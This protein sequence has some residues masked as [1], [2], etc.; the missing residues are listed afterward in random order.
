M[1]IAIKD[2]NK[3]RVI[4]TA[5]LTIAPNNITSI[6]GNTWAEKRVHPGD[7]LLISSTGELS[8]SHAKDGQVFLVIDICDE[9]ILE[10]SG[11]SNTLISLKALTEPIYLYA[12]AIAELGYLSDISNAELE[13]LLRGKWATIASLSDPL[14]SFSD[15]KPC[16]WIH[17]E[18][19]KIDLFPDIQFGI[20]PDG[21]VLD[22]LGWDGFNFARRFGVEPFI[23]L[24]GFDSETHFMGRMKG[25]S[26][27]PLTDWMPIRMRLYLCWFK[28]LSEK[29]PKSI[30]SPDETYFC[31]AMWRAEP[32]AEAIKVMQFDVFVL[33]H[34][35]WRLATDGRD[36]AFQCERQRSYAEAICIR[37]NKDPS[38]P[39]IMEGITDAGFYL[40]GIKPTDASLMEV[41][42]T[43][44]TADLSTAI[45]RA[46]QLAQEG[47]TKIMLWEGGVGL[48]VTELSASDRRSML[49]QFLNY[50]EEIH[51]L[52]LMTVG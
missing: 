42:L 44:P 36:V 29:Y 5:Y 49:K 22:D 47:H 4:T 11:N 35:A 51:L 8:S 52:D 3:F 28:P 41:H 27:S 12:E 14:L 15:V 46:D 37:A 50:G 10:D 21:T 23:G 31:Q 7:F 34:K 6:L 2:D 33:R 38:D 43:W 9:S 13:I 40:T 26:R 32:D 45:S 16:K 20:Q 39:H 24:S 18:N 30:P 48:S 19:D 25:I 17:D 1:Q